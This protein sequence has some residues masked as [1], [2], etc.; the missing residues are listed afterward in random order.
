MTMADSKLENELAWHKP[1]K[2]QQSLKEES[3][4]IKVSLTGAVGQTLLLDVSIEGVPVAAVADTGAQSTR[5]MFHR[6]HKHM[7]SHKESPCQSWSI[8]TLWPSG[9][10]LDITAMANLR[11]SADCF[12]VTVLVFV[13]PESEQDCLLGMNTLPQLGVKVHRANEEP[14]RNSG[15][16]DTKSWIQLVYTVVIPSHKAKFVEAKLEGPLPEGKEFVFE[17]HIAGMSARGAVASASLVTVLSEGHVFVPVENYD[18]IDARLESDTGLGFV[19]RQEADLC[20]C[21]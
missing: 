5:S 19:V 8:S 1:D 18:G 3:C 13:Q 7:K 10:K 16:K 4:C 12:E 14:L 2:E 20:S 11:F 21:E 9:R 15:E 6:I 17:P